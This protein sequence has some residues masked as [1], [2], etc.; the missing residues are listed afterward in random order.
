[1]KFII[2]CLLVEALMSQ[3]TTKFVENMSCEDEG[4]YPYIDGYRKP[5]DMVMNTT[6][7]TLK[8]QC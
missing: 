1:M 7:E 4:A 5:S 3:P 2:A 6:I 8:M